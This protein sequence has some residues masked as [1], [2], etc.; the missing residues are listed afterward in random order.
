MVFNN[1]II[2]TCRWTRSIF[3]TGYRKELEETDIYATLTQDRT[4]HL[5]DIIS[6]TWKKEIESCVKKKNNTNNLHLLKVLLRLFGKP[7][8]VIGIAKGVMELFSKY[9]NF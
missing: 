7:F 5:G 2:N 3:R 8:M 6:K 1:L 4:K 9:V